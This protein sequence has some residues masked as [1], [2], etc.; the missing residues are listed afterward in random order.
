[1]VLVINGD[2]VRVNHF[3]KFKTNLN[4][5]FLLCFNLKKWQ[6]KGLKTKNEQ[7]FFKSFGKKINLKPL[8]IFDP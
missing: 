7:Q 4:G 2:S 1:M 3:F 8:Y 6:Q 5:Y